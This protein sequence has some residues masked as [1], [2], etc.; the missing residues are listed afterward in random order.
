MTEAL[1]MLMPA[2]ALALLHFLWQGALVGLLAWLALVLL[3]NARPQARYVVACLALL[4]CVLLPVWS[5]AQ[6][7]T[8]EDAAAVA[9]GA[10]AAGGIDTTMPA[11]QGGALRVL[12]APSVG[13]LP[14]IVALWAAGVCLLSLRMACGLLWVRRLCRDAHAE[15][16]SRWQACVDRLAPRLGIGRRVLLRLVDAGDSPVT[17]GWWRPWAAI[18][19]QAWT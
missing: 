8:G 10:L 6:A 18:R 15:A 12:P 17:A 5:L 11:T 19:T 4:A 13:A 16:G 9:R 14:W 1:A 3:S 7:L 2:L